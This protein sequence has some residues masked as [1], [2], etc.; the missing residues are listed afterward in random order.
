M[1]SM[2]SRI[3]PRQRLKQPSVSKSNVMGTAGPVFQPSDGHPSDFGRPG[4]G[5]KETRELRRLGQEPETHSLRYAYL[6]NSKPL[7][8]IAS[9]ADGEARNLINDTAASGFLAPTTIPAEKTVTFCAPGGKGP[10]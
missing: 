7:F 4:D 5:R 9:A 10:T 3:E 2:T 8:L 6:G 1:R